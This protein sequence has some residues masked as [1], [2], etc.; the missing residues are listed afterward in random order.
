MTLVMLLLHLR[1]FVDYLM[2]LWMFLNLVSCCILR[3]P[4]RERIVDD[5]PGGTKH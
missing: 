2:R 5:V 3:G 1:Y 4:V